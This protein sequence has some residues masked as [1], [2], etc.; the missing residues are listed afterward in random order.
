[1]TQCE[2][3]ASHGTI[4]LSCSLHPSLAPRLA[5]IELFHIVRQQALIIAL[6]YAKQVLA[7]AQPLVVKGEYFIERRLKIQL[8][9]NHQ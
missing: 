2:M 6:A 3:G 7:I 1:M 5:I 4:Q 9:K 8:G